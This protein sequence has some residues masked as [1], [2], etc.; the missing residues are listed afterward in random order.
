MIKGYV[1]G[2]SRDYIMIKNDKETTH[3]L[4]RNT[5]NEKE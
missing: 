2:G 5:K 3:N 4:I 1:Y